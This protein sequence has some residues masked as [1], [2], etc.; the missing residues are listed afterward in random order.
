MSGAVSA[1]LLLRL[2]VQDH[3]ERYADTLDRGDF[4][5]WP[6]FFSEA[7]LYQVIPRENWDRGLPL[8]AIRCES[9]GMLR[10]RVTAIRSTM[11]YEP[12]YLRHLVSGVR[13]SGSGDETG[14]LAARANYGVFE[15]LV[16]EPTHILQTGYYEAELV[17]HGAALL[18]RRLSCVFDSVV[19]PNSLVYPI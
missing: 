16:D 13:V 10:D 18:F 15:T 17:R 6:E 5:A 4:E 19:V 7:C 3:F 11:M 12:R 2:E 8:A 14:A 1:S 9:R